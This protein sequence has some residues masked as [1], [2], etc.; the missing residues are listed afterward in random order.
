MHCS[1]VPI[2][3]TTLAILAFPLSAAE[4]QIR[5]RFLCSDYSGGQVCIVN[6]DGLIEWRVA[7]KAPQDCWLL[8]NG[9]ILFSHAEGAKEVTKDKQVVWEYQAPKGA[10]VHAAQPLPD[11]NVLVAEC[12][13]KRLVEVDRSGTVIREVPVN[14]RANLSAHMQFR[15]ARKLANGNYLVAFVSDRRIAEIDTSGVVVREFQVPGNPVQVEPLQNGNL[16]V[17]CGYARKIQ[18]TNPAGEVVWSLGESDLPPPPLHSITG[19]QRL[20]NGNTVICNWLSGESPQIYEVTPDKQLVWSYAD[21]SLFKSINQV[22][23]L[24]EAERPNA[25]DLRP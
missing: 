4:P 13:T 20:R 18:E 5:H 14:V 6:A 25:K 23:I 24:D 7:A 15:G 10:E 19:A 12:G 16:L 9:N 11:G 22:R 3:L 17:T 2:A 8:P 1:L 21:R